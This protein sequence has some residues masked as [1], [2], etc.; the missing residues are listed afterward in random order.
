MGA[1]LQG[2]IMKAFENITWDKFAEKHPEHELV[3]L[4]EMKEKIPEL[5]K[6]LST[7]GTLIT[8][9]SKMTWY[10]GWYWII[11]LKKPRRKM[12]ALVC[13]ANNMFSIKIC[14]GDYMI[15]ES[16][17]DYPKFIKS[18]YHANVMEFAGSPS[19]LQN[20]DEL[21]KRFKGIINIL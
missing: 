2:V 19:T 6:L 16:G 8:P 5:E 18:D 10:A 7:L 20:F 21:V 12:H 17:Y 9:N 11:R 15:N 3:K 14:K 4:S 13:Y 1:N